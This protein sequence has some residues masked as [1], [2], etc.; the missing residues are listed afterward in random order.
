MR[1]VTPHK[2]HGWKLTPFGLRLLDDGTLNDIEHLAREYY[3]CW[4]TPILMKK[5]SKARALYYGANHPTNMQEI[6]NLHREF[7]LGPIVHNPPAPLPPRPLLNNEV[8]GQE[9]EAG[10]AG[11]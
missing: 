7:E 6:I 3:R 8:D 5:D 11:A 4:E 2:A 1:L 9:P 10:A